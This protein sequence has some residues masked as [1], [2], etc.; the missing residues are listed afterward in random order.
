MSEKVAGSLNLPFQI[1]HGLKLHEGCIDQIGGQAYHIGVRA[2]DFRN[3]NHPYPFLDAV[4]ARFIK[5]LAGLNVKVD[6]IIGELFQLHLGDA[7]HRLL[8]LF[9][10]KTN[11]GNHLMPVSR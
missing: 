4:G 5:R 3:A 8:L 1:N 11:R 2:L 10:S 9:C 7:A 6:F